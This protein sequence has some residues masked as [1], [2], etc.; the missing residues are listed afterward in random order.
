MNFCWLGGH[1][2]HQFNQVLVCCNCGKKV[3][4]L[5]PKDGK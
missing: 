3:S 4:D 1:C 5:P 2:F